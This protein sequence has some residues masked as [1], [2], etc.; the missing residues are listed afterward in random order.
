MGI[1]IRIQVWKADRLRRLTAA[2]AAKG[3]STKNDGDG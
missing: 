1:N 2:T 3:H